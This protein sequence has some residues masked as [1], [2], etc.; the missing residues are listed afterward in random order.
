MDKKILIFMPSIEGGGVEKNLF[1]V[2]NFLIKK[3]KKLSVITISKNYKKKFNKSIEFISLSSDIWD[4]Y[5]RRFKYFL[6][7]L[8]LIKEILKNKNLI[9]FSFQANIY[10]IVICKLFGVKVISRSNSAPYG[11]SKNWV[12]RNIFKIFLNFADKI[13]VNS[14]QFKKDLKKEFNVNAICIYNPLNTNEIIQKSKKRSLSIFNSNK[15][16]KIL[17]IGRFVDQKDQITLLRSLNYIK[18]DINYEAVIVGKGI[19][20][21]SLKNYIIKNKLKDKVKLINF[22]ENP[23]NYIKQADL[24][25]L[26]SKFEGLPNVLLEALV[27]KKFSISSNCRTGPKEILLNGKGGLLFKVGNSKELSKKIIYYSKNKNKCNKLLKNAI[28]NLYRFDYK[29]NLEKYYNLIMSV[30]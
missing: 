8:L 2:S 20:K 26:T 14:E 13:M 29:K 16:I 28:N 25:I 9:V 19:L 11:W 6:A 12:K 21:A 24:F 1:L 3:F 5:G 18:N 23:Y 17:N 30:R 27:L 15:K 7:I 10:C 4:K 22:V